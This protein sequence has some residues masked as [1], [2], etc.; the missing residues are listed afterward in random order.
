MAERAMPDAVWRVRGRDVPLSRP[1]VLGILNVTPDSFSDGGR[2]REPGPA[3]DRG[4][5]MAAEGADL[6]DVGGESTRPGAEPVDADEEW[7]RVGPVVEALA[8]AGVGVTLDT[9]KAEVARRGLDA[10]AVAV[11]DVSGLRFEPE[12]ADVCAGTGG[13]LVLMHMRGEPR[14][15]QSDLVYE[16]LIGEVARFLAAQASLA[17]QR[18]VEPDRI[19]VDPGLGFGKSAE[20]SLEL[21]ARCDAFAALGYPVMVGPS[22]KSFIGRLLDLPVEERLEG[23]IAACVSALFRGARLFRVHDVAPVRRALDLAEAVR[24]E[25]PGATARRSAVP[26]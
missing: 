15:M 19:A 3:V 20:G 10:G 24:R 5:A 2:W 22:R 4:L 16:D 13:G 25:I 23:T 26:T 18:G 9:T 11:N 1:V 7:A 6:V 17:G 8:A 14:T 21:L 12:I